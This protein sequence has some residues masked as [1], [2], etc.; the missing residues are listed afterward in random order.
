MHA[1]YEGLPAELKRRLEGMTVLHDF[2]KFWEMMRREK[3]SK[4]PP[5]TD[6]QRRRSRRSRIRRSSPIRS[7]AARC[8]TPIPATPCAST[9]CRRR[10]A[11]RR[12]S[13]CSRTS[14]KPEYRYAF[15]WQEGDVL[16]WEDIGTIHNAVADYG[17]GRASPH[18]ALPGD[19]G[20]LFLRRKEGGGGAE[21]ESAAAQKVRAAAA[22]LAALLRFVARSRVHARPDRRAERRGDLG[23]LLV[24]AARPA[25]YDRHHRGS[26]RQHLPGSRGALP[27]DTGAQRRP[28]PDT[29]VA[30]LAGESQAPRRPR[31]HRRRRLRPGR[32]VRRRE[33]RWPRTRW[34]ACSTSRSRCST[35]GRAL[36]QLS[37]LQGRRVAIGAEGSGAHVLALALLKANGIEPGGPH[38]AARS[39]RAGRGRTRC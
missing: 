9:S 6:A 12:S 2:E 27:Q 10:K 24:R 18:Q 8:S 32:R 26:R 15:H 16:M 19:G 38:G 37:Q 29:F 35:P 33:Y 23:G 22:A 17:P 13:S 20:P 7:P 5:L 28:A 39:C 3:G 14:S 34:A 36:R 31:V 4:R 1:A 25:R 11:T 30:R 21:R